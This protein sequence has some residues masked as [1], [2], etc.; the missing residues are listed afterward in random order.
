M[1]ECPPRLIDKDGGALGPASLVDARTRSRAEV[2]PPDLHFQKRVSLVL[3]EPSALAA[4]N[5]PSAQVVPL[6]AAVLR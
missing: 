5:S 6:P 2:G 4:I 3:M 1:C